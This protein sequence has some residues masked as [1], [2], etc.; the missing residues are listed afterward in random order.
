MR[1]TKLGLLASALLCSGCSIFPR[2]HAIPN[3][4]VPHRLAEEVD[5]M[6]LV[7]LPDGSF[8][9]E[10]KRVPEGWW[11]ASPLVVE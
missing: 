1:L 8:I 2:S 4:R 5:V 7:R 11:I 9:K 6:I 10:K 3:D